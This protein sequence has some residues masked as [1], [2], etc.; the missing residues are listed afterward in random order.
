M[1]SKARRSINVGMPTSG[2]GFLCFVFG[3][4]ASMDKS[5]ASVRCDGHVINFDEVDLT[6]ISG[7][8]GVSK[9]LDPAPHEQGH[10]RC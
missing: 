4:G 8:V 5:R 1:V 10:C 9:S 6:A 2:E 7:F 3:R